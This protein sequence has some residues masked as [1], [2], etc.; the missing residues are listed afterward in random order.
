MNQL[1]QQ[2][3]PRKIRKW[4]SFYS[5]IFFNSKEM[6][7]VCPSSPQLGKKMA[8]WVPADAEAVLEL[9]PGTGSITK[10]LLSQ[11]IQE[12][13]LFLLERSVS[14]SKELHA[15]FPQANISSGCAT[16]LS[17]VYQGRHFSYIV[18]SLPLRLF[19]EE[20]VRLF[21]REILSILNP[22]GI[23]VQFTYGIG[24]NR[25]KNYLKSEVVLLETEWEVMNIPP[26]RIEVY[27][28]MEQV[29]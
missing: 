29:Q 4:V 17:K 7:C 3:S 27:K 6:G 18:S 28:K 24:I 25:L 10:A 23:F 13:N 16:Q 26:A 5:E 11:G 20:Q 22:G 9:G 15:L 14:L 8:K 12:Q 19:S 21:S 2:F 1:V